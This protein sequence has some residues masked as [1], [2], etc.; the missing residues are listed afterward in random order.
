MF[1]M[2]RLEKIC[3]GHGLLLDG[4]LDDAVFEFAGF[5]LGPELVAGALA[6]LLLLLLLLRFPRAVLGRRDEQVEQPLGDAAPWPSP[7]PGRASPA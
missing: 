4:E 1:S 6:L 5:E 2:P 3:T 7:A